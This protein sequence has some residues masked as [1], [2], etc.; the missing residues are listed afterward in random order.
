[1]IKL[2]YRHGTILY[3]NGDVLF[4]NNVYMDKEKALMLLYFGMILFKLRWQI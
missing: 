1:M 3:R 4:F 2:E